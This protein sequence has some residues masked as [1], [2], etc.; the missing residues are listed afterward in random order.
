M[1]NERSDDFKKQASTLADA[2]QERMAGVRD[3]AA[4]MVEEAG[5]TVRPAIN[6]ARARAEHAVGQAQEMADDTYQRGKS[7]VQGLAENVRGD[8]LLGAVAA[9]AV[10]YGLSLLLHGRK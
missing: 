6:V 8:A 1:S 2:A 4:A 7:A 10:G 3:S 5:R 9:F